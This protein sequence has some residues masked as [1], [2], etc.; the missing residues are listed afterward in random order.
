[1]KKESIICFMVLMVFVSASA[2][3]ARDAEDY[4]RDS[5]IFTDSFW[6]SDMPKEPHYKF[7]VRNY[8]REDRDDPYYH[9]VFDGDLQ[10]LKDLYALRIR[11]ES[12]QSN[13]EFLLRV[14]AHAGHVPV[15]KY[16]LAQGVF[17]DAGV[18]EENGTRNKGVTALM[19]AALQ[20]QKE[21]VEY[22]IEQGASVNYQTPYGE[23]ALLFA[24]KGNHSDTV[25]VL[26]RHGADINIKTREGNTP[27]LAA[28]FAGFPYTLETLIR[29]GADVNARNQEGDTALHAAAM[30]FSLY[31]AKILILSGA[32]PNARDD[33]GRTPLDFVGEGWVNGDGKEWS[34]P[35]ESMIKLLKHYQ[36][37]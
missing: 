31:C 1:M 11:E 22:L 29:L 14:A 25:Q 34:T 6:P 16:L 9:A 27:L 4:Y 15:A 2:C 33:N 13:G 3:M 5:I 8:K 19:F 17:I 36:N 37:R 18:P 35:R 26:V 21:M 12:P 32:D 20:G 24:A 7:S 10:G 28:A 23:S 30:E